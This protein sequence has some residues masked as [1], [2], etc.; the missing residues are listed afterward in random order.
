ME[1]IRNR[2]NRLR[3]GIWFLL[4]IIGCDSSAK[5]ALNDF[6]GIQMPLEEQK[7]FKIISYNEAQ[8]IRYQSSPDMNPNIFAW[9]EI[10]GRTI[11]IKINNNSRQALR[12]DYLNDRFTLTTA[13]GQ[14]FILDKGRQ[15]AYPVNKFI[16]PRRQATYRFALPAHFWDTVGMRNQQSQTAEYLEEFWTGMDTD[17]ISRKLIKQIAVTLGGVRHII[18]KPV[19]I[20][21]KNANK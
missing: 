10:E 18:M 9:A 3:W 21:K 12:S 5:L 4:F 8:G 17:H 1:K 2:K 6:F 11:Q 13:D 16:E 19:P 15:A 14:K 7:Y 20:S